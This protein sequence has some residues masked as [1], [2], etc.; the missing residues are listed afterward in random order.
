MMKVVHRR[1]LLRIVGT[2]DELVV[3]SHVY[4]LNKNIAP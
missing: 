4:A 1:A 2:F 3:V